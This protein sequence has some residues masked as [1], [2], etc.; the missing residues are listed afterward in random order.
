MLLRGAAA[1]EALGLRIAVQLAPGDIVALS[2]DIGAGKTTLARAILA[3]LGHV[4]EVPSPTYTLVQTYAPPSVRIPVWHCDLYRIENPA[5]INEIGLEEALADSVLLVEWP[6]RMGTR[7]WP[8]ALV[9]RL[10]VEAD[11]TRRLT[12]RVPPAWETRWP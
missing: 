8:D 5:E 9:L 11:S 12:A 7:L 1:T 2:G 4:G 10:D 3:G 6:E